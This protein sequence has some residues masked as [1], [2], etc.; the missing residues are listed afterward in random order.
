MQW[1]VSLKVLGSLPSFFPLCLF[2][3][4]RQMQDEGQCCHVRAQAFSSPLQ[5]VVFFSFSWRGGCRCFRQAA[6]RPPSPRQGKREGVPSPCLCHV[7][8]VCSSSPSLPR[9]GLLLP[10]FPP[11]F[12]A[13]PS[14]PIADPPRPSQQPP[15]PLFRCC[16]RE[17]K[18]PQA[19]GASEVP[20][21]PTSSSPS[22]SPPGHQSSPARQGQPF[23]QCFP[24][25]LLPL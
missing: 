12:P 17:G 24:L 11:R 10:S 2:L 21:C 20:A 15:P 1:Q 3:L 7:R 9:E 4:S 13:F 25:L 8:G 16:M 5:C 22:P 23:L 6:C 18:S 14:F 19:W